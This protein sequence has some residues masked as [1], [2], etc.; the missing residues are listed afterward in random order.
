MC[1]NFL[2][3]AL[4]KTPIYMWP[5]WRNRLHFYSSLKSYRKF[6]ERE[7]VGGF[8]IQDLWIALCVKAGRSLNKKMAYQY[9][10]KFSAEVEGLWSGQKKVKRKM[11]REGKSYVLSS[12]GQKIKLVDFWLSFHII[13]TDT[14]Y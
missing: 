12:V 9:L 6:S 2:D 13:R 11:N 5:A 8:F 14:R 4:Q 10:T 1:K 3:H 7:T